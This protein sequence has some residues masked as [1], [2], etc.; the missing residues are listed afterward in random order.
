M[1]S[2]TEM[3]LI[4]YVTQQKTTPESIQRIKAFCEKQPVGSFIVYR[5][6]QRSRE[7]RENNY[8]YSSSISKDVAVAEFSS[9]PGKCCVFTIHLI[10]IPFIDINKWIGNKIGDYAEEKEYIFLG[11]GKFYKDHQLTNTGFTYKGNGEYECWYKIHDKET[12]DTRTFDL[13][14]IL[15][16][17]PEDAYE[18]IS[19]PDDIDI[20]LPPN[21]NITDGEKQII[22]DRI[23]ELKNKSG[24]NPKIYKKR[25][26][27]QISSKKRKSIKGRHAVK[28]SKT[29]KLKIR[30]I[31]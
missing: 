26:H 3:D 4:D 18:F 21:M 20:L 19:S 27:R 10:N 15:N 29:R 6:H 13:D 17:I 30:R 7:I 23:E 16:I 14:R 8:W 9:G 1:D 2:I 11:G 22:F 28:S 25:R 24:G 5:G 31:K 12:T